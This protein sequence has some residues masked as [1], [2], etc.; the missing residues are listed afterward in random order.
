MAGMLDLWV[1]VLAHEPVSRSREWLQMKGECAVC[2]VTF[3]AGSTVCPDL[4]IGSWTVM[5]VP[6]PISL[7]MAK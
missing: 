6:L 1:R 4:V 7:S 5:I 3:S 2:Q